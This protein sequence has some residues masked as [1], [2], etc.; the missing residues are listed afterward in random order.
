MARAAIRFNGREV[1]RRLLRMFAPVGAPADQTVLFI[2]PSDEAN[3][4]PWTQTQLLDELHRLHR[5][6]NTRPVV[7]R[8]RAQVPRIKVARDDNVLVR[9]RTALQVCDDV[10]AHRVGQ[11]LRR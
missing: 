2:H 1:A 4:A 10:V 6:G 9:M 7:N 8:A 5:D 3:R 11:L